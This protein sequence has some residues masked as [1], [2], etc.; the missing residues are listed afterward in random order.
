M[1]RLT[2]LYPQP[3]D[4]DQFEK[5]Y[6]AHIQL[7]HEKTGIPGDAKPYTIT[8]FQQTPT[9][10]PPYYLMF[11]MPFN[12]PEDLQSAMS[13]QGMQEVDSDAQ[14]ISTGGGPVMMIGNED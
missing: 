8:R 14:R 9:G 10:L 4:I 6:Q 7:L 11:S 12:S 2:V 13:S 5:D 3:T 1:I